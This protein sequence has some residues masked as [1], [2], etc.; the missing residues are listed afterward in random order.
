MPSPDKK[1]LIGAFI[2]Q[3]VAVI[4]IALGSLVHAQNL[5]TNGGFENGLTGWS[6]ATSGGASASFAVETS[7]QYAGAKAMRVAIT[8]SGAALHN[9]QTRA[10]G[11]SISLPIGTPTTITFRARASTAG[12]KVR[13]VMQ[14]IQRDTAL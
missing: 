12:V 13:F 4:F 7:L 5:V 1:R 14:D 11:T 6:N 9:V 3:A 10:T 2:H 8:N